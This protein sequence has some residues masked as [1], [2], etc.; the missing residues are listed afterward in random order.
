M[1]EQVIF[2]RMARRLDD[3]VSTLS[4]LQLEEMDQL[5]PELQPLAA[6]QRAAQVTLQRALGASRSDAAGRLT[7]IL[8]GNVRRLVRSKCRVLPGGDMEEVRR[9][10]TEAFQTLDLPPQ[11]MA[12]AP[13]SEAADLPCDLSACASEAVR[14]SNCCKLTSSVTLRKWPEGNDS[15]QRTLTWRP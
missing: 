10:V 1:A 7:A 8:K 13:S 5:D 11:D 6:V 9:Q 14:F 4:Q 12:R 15:K 2:E 3:F